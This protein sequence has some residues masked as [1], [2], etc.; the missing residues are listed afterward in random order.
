[1]E[2]EV[3]VVVAKSLTGSSVIYLAEKIPFD[4]CKIS[5]SEIAPKSDSEC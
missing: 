5:I 1:M 2:V 3:E 4:P